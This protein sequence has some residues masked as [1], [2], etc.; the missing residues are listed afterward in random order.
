MYA[1]ILFISSQYVKKSCIKYA[2]QRR[3]YIHKTE[4]ILDINACTSFSKRL[5]MEYFS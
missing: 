3:L 5:E 2:Y 1:R 4:K